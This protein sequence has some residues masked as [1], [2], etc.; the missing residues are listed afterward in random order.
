MPQALREPALGPL[1]EQ[2]DAGGFIHGPSLNHAVTG[3][4]LR[5]AYLTHA[6]ATARD[7]MAIDLSSARARLANGLLEGI[8]TG[9]PLGALLGYRFERGLKEN[10]GDPSLAQYIPAF[11]DR[12]PLLADHITPDSEGEADRSQGGPPCP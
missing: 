6:D 5:N 9:Q 1:T 4:V 2:P 12:Y 8:R 7:R 3:A 10:H 11:R